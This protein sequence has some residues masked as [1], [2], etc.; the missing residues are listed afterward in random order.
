MRGSG[1]AQRLAI[2][3]CAG[4]R[5]QFAEAHEPVALRAGDGAGGLGGFLAE[6]GEAPVVPEG[7]EVVYVVTT[8]ESLVIQDIRPEPQLFVS[9][10]NTYRLHTL[11]AELSDP[12]DP[13]YLDASIIEFGKTRAADVLAVVAEAGICADLFVEGAAFDVVAAGSAAGLVAGATQTGAGSDLE[14][15]LAPL[16]APVEQVEV[17]LTD[18]SGRVVARQR[19]GRV[20][21]ATTVN[22]PVAAQREGLYVVSVRSA[23]GLQ[24]EM[25]PIR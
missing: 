13:D 23:V 15:T 10:P 3:R 17:F 8:S 5:E 16:D 11:V 24:A 19:V 2:Q 7:Y 4:G 1:Y 9:D 20:D 25:V 6:V 21:A 14:V 22:L 18:H 12:S